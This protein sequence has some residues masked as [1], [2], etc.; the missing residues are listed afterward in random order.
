MLASFWCFFDDIWE[1]LLV[2][3]CCRFY[4]VQLQAFVKTVRQMYKQSFLFLF[5]LQFWG[6]VAA[7]PLARPKTTENAKHGF[8]AVSVSWNI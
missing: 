8:E 1:F 2:I 4:Y 6:V 7:A 3:C 5:F